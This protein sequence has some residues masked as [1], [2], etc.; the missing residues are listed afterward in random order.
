MNVELQNDGKLAVIKPAADLSAMA[1]DRLR[2]EW[3]QWMAGA[4][5]VRTVV[6]DMSGVNF[7]DSSGMGLLI[8]MLKR[9]GERGGA[10]RLA[11]L[12]RS[13]RMV[14]DIT[15]TTKVFKIFDTL[16]DALRADA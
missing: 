8:A 13:V 7:M 1:V 14:F 9:M 2:E 3:T 5:D 6:M 4:D 10:L 12:Q 15:R 11:N 16:E